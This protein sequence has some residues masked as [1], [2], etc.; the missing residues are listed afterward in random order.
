MGAPNHC[1]ERRITALGAEK[2]QQ[3][4]MHF[5]QYSEFA[6]EIPQVRTWGRQTGFLAGRHLTSPLDNRKLSSHFAMK[7]WQ[8]YEAYQ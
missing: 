7:I 5:L 3:C 1:R 4:H 6:S 8:P 2:S